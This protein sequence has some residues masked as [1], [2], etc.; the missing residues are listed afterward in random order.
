MKGLR[1]RVDVCRSANIHGYRA[2]A[3]SLN[4]SC[5]RPKSVCNV[6]PCL[7]ANANGR[8]RGLRKRLVQTILKCKMIVPSAVQKAPSGI[9]KKRVELHMFG[10]ACISTGVVQ[11]KHF[12]AYERVVRHNAHIGLRY[13]LTRCANERILPHHVNG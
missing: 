2:G 4:R 12:V 6:Q 8:S 1:F 7:F 5:A 9:A 11:T 13:T 10:G 3:I